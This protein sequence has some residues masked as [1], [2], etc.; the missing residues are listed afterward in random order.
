MG[1]VYEKAKRIFDAH[2]IVEKLT[3][4]DQ[5][6]TLIKQ[7]DGGEYGVNL[8]AQLVMNGWREMEEGD[9]AYYLIK[10]KSSHKIAAYF[11]LKAGL[12]YESNDYEHL[13][14]TEREFVDLLIA[15]M[16][17]K[18]N[19][20]LQDYKASGYYSIEKYDTL[21]HKA[22]DIIEA[23][24]NH[25]N[26]GSIN[27]KRTFSAVEIQNLCRNF[28]YNPPQDIDAPIGLQTFWFAAVPRILEVSDIIG[29]KYA[30][31]FAA[32]K[33]YRLSSVDRYSLIEYY[34]NSFLFNG[35]IDDALAVIRP[36]YDEFCYE[37]YCEIS[38]LRNNRYVVWDRYADQ[39]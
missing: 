8:A 37:M 6:R 33:D 10:D 28:D 14:S 2:Y 27:V 29:C 15:A 25:K 7:F 31:L 18:D 30:Y 4:D 16:E 39:Y 12:L 34:K 19:Q 13:E 17:E 5:N 26:T 24:E 21:Y 3:A 9:S 35:M 36:K 11:S 20:L 23:R 22:E 1:S 38:E 32:D